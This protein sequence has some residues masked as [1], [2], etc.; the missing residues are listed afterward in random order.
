MKST[1]VFLGLL[2]LVPALAGASISTESQ[3][4]EPVSAVAFLEMLSH[5]QESFSCEESRVSVSE[6][7][8][9][10]I[11]VNWIGDPL[12][13]DPCAECDDSGDC[14]SCCK[15]TG[16]GNRTCKNACTNLEAQ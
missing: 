2:L 5:S 6:Q 13:F 8:E 4:A 10:T 9:E 15:C 1:Y 16:G 7:P 14:F 12:L 11:S 3:V